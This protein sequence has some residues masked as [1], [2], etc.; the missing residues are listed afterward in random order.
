MAA[1]IILDSQGNT[2][3]SES[4]HPLFGDVSNAR[5][6]SVSK[7]IDNA[8]KL[9]K[10]GKEI[11][12]RKGA[13]RL[14]NVAHEVNEREIYAD[15]SLAKEVF[16]KEERF[17]KGIEKPVKQK[18][19]IVKVGNKTLREGKMSETEKTKIEILEEAKEEL[20]NLFSSK[21]ALFS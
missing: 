18:E 19:S 13:E 15:D 9:S 20:S 8:V 5:E 3:S 1:E 2:I 16:S 4:I 21:I 17:N 11:F 10:L 7:E 6:E 14:D 12:N